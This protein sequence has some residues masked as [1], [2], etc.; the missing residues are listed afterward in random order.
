MSIPQCLSV[1]TRLAKAHTILEEFSLPDRGDCVGRVSDAAEGCSR[2]CAR[3]R[4]AEALLDG[5]AEGRPCAREYACG[6]RV[7]GNGGPLTSASLWRCHPPWSVEGSTRVSVASKGVMH[8]PRTNSAFVITARVRWSMLVASTS[9]RIRESV[10][11]DSNRLIVLAA[12]VGSVTR[13]RV[14]AGAGNDA[15][16]LLQ[17]VLHHVSH[18]AAIGTP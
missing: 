11:L 4:R 5:G 3:R 2:R 17:I 8:R 7:D 15:G 9:L 10:A 1:Q 13:Y 18:S 6:A 12:L 16:R 14:A